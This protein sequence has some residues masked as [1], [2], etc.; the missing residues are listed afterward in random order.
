MEQ[1]ENTSSVIDLFIGKDL[2]HVATPQIADCIPK[3][4]R[5]GI[6]Q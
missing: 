2:I 5:A 3:L 6:R 4:R 1:A